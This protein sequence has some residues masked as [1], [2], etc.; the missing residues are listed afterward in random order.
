MNTTLYIKK[1]LSMG[2]LR[3]LYSDTDMQITDAALPGLQ[4]RYSAVTGRKVFYLWYR[5]KGTMRQRNM[6]LGTLDEFSL[7]DIRAL[8]IKLKKDISSGLDPQIAQRQR[9]KENAEQ[10]ARR[11]RV[12]ELTPIFLEKHCRENNRPKTLTYNE[13]MIR[14]YIDPIMGEKM[15]DEID[16]GYVQDI[17]DKI[18]NTKTIACADH[19]FRLFSTFMNWCEKYNHRAINS[20]PCRLIKKAKAPKFKYTILDSN[21]YNK[22]FEALDK[23][24]EIGNYAPQAV[25]AV[26]AIALT[27][28]RSGEITELE[29]DELDLE[30]GYLRLN[31]RKTDAFDVPLGEPA[32]M[33]IKQALEICKS[34]QYVFHSPIDST[35]P[36]ID[37]RRVFWWALDKAGLPRMRIHDLRHSFAS[38]ATNI[39]EDIRT[40]KD[41]LGHTKITTTEIYTHT[42]DKAARKSADNVSKAIMG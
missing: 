40:L 13:G 27:G 11:K 38:T 35:R 10:E 26:K 19:V 25:L 15:I 3:N 1:N 31:K 16:L 9:A 18:K 30:N 7:I 33:V 41:V 39:G 6:R 17:Y 22:L 36:L 21:G 42:S 14:L 32:I 34:K 37:L 12:K 5:V 24:L 8:A 4:M 28:C 23:A 20:N 2:Y 29:H